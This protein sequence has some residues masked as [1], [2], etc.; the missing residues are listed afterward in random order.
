MRIVFIGPPGAGKG[1]QCDRLIRF[2]QIPHLSTGEMLRETLQQGSALGRQIA[3]YIDGG[4]LAPDYL[5]MR[6]VK[7]RLRDRDCRKGCLFDGFP[8]TIPQAQL[9]DE[10]LQELDDAIDLVLY[11]QCPQ[12]ELVKRLLKRATIE[13]RA[14]DN[15]DAISARLNI[16][17][18]TTSPLLDY[19][20]RH[21]ILR[22]IDGTLSPVEVTAQIRGHITHSSVDPKRQ[23]Q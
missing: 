12:E 17:R 15:A 23:S 13:C 18:T 1:T 2:L 8:R 5:V 16:F 10:H 3:G 14:D 21:G 20:E 19:Y 7:Q 6:M 9:L 22:T 11:L 4:N